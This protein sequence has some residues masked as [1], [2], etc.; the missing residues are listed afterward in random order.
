VTVL[1]TGG[2][3]FVG[4]HVVRGLAAAGE[5]VVSLGIGEGLGEV[6][7]AFLGGLGEQVVFENG[8][9]TDLMSV[10][11]V[12]RDHSV[13][14]IVHGAA[15][16]A[17]GAT[18]RAAAHDAAMVNVGGTATV[19]EAARVRGVRR[20][21]YLSSAMVYGAGEPTVSLG[22]DREP[23]PL[24]IYALTKHA[25][26]SLVVRYA[27]LFGLDVGILRLSAP[28]GPLERPTESRSLMSP[29]FG[30]CRAALAGQAVALD[31]DLERDFTFVGDTADAVVR[32][33]RARALP[34]RVYNVAGGVN[35]RFSEVLAILAGLC[36][37]FAV[38]RGTR[39]DEEESFFQASRRGPLAIARARRDLGWHPQT[40]LVD[41]LQTYLDWLGRHRL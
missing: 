34:E 20:L 31:A 16:T 18:E 32:A 36:P 22:E 2:E 8:D 9:V 4:M 21:V 10:E 1:V 19:L 6:G 26:E 27:D 11:R 17:I 24:G 15:V 28:Y 29:I 14:E 30:W 33:V 5:R 3:G 23:R 37:G 7:Q 41:G 40:S 25:G 39:P 38:A 13:D 35:V 12:A